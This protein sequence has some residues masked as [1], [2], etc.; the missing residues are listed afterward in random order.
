MSD[1]YESRCGV[2]FT[3][4]DSDALTLLR[5]GQLMPSEVSREWQH[6]TASFDLVGAA[7][8]VD[9]DGGNSRLTLEF[10]A[11]ISAPTVA[12]LERRLFKREVHLNTHREGVVRLLMA[13][14][15]GQP[16]MLTDWR[17]L[18]NSADTRRCT[19]DEAPDG[20]AAWGLLTCSFT[21]TNPTEA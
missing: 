3:P 2:C 11:L 8:G 10:S 17:A 16:T 4:T 7:Y 12:E 20:A 21:L 19:Y 18:L 9:E 6:V 5:F 13:Y 1:F 14:H 15:E